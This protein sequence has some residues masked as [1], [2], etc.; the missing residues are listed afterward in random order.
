M[1]LRLGIVGLGG[2]WER[3][4]SSALRA[5]GDRFEIRAVCEPV[6]ERAQQ[7]AAELG[8]CQVDGYQVL[9]QRDDIDGV[10]VLSPEWFG[11]L[12]ILA[13]CDA[14]KAV[15]CATPLIV[16]EQR[17]QAIRRRVVESG[18]S[19]VAEFPLR[20]A[21]ATLRL[22]ELIATQLGRPELL[23]CHSRETARRKNG[24]LRPN[25][26]RKLIELVDW[27]RYVV[28]SD[29]ISVSGVSHEGS[30]GGGEDYQMMSLDFAAPG[31][32]N[33]LAQISCGRYIAADWREAATFRPPA[34][35]QI[36]CER[37]VAFIDLPSTLIWFDD[38]GRHMESLESDRPMGEQLLIHFLRCVTSL[39]QQTSGLDDALLAQKIYARFRSSQQQGRR[40]EI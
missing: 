21:P 20:H 40:L 23:F 18:I 5:L 27:C 36:R 9:V 30:G 13:A 16:D 15:Y 7:V 8:A 24:K 10:L 6:A 33:I 25:M 37:G 26:A 2:G 35:L 32:R 1:K 4:Y 12:P 11:V 39:V 3:R 34:A 29:P 31:D 28:D 17:A 38:A 19:F 14:Q 22:K